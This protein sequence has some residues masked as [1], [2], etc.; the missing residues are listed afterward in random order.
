MSTV[1]KSTKMLG[2]LNYRLRVT[3]TDGRL[4]IGQL[5]AF[6]RHMNLVLA[7]CEEFRKLKIKGAKQGERREREEKRV[8]GL[9]ILRG[10]L[11]VNFTI[12]SPPPAQKDDRKQGLG[13]P[14]AGPGLARPAGRGMPI[15]G[16]PIPAGPVP[17]LVG[18]GRIGGPAGAMPPMGMPPG[19]PPMPPGMPPLPAG[20]V[21]P[22]LPPMPPGWRP[23]MPIPAM[24]GMPPLPLA[25]LPP[26]PP[27]FRPP[28]PPGAGFPPGAFPP[29]PP[30]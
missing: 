16:A 22:P 5:L 1:E 3:I 4:M 26:M 28:M 25:G 13:G 6:D 10:D 11:V 29:R 18:P 21:R 17:G 24:P 19:M 2:L 15:V 30:Q 8:L 7:D 12:E 20:A 23:G 27:G 9:V 14:A